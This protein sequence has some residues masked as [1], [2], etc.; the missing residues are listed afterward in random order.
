MVQM[1]Y[2]TIYLYLWN[3]VFKIDLQKYFNRLLQPERRTSKS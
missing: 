3:K 1:N 2:L